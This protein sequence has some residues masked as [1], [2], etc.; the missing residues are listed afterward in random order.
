[1][2][3]IS[4]LPQH[5]MTPHHVDCWYDR[6]TRCWVVQ[7]LTVDDFQVGD[8]TYVHSRREAVQ[9]A[10][11]RRS[12]IAAVGVSVKLGRDD[13]EHIMRLCRSSASRLDPKRSKARPALERYVAAIEAALAAVGTESREG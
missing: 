2:K 5:D 1:M 10:E 8:S 12:D 3:I 4:Q 13:W 9:E 6:T 7:T 11:S